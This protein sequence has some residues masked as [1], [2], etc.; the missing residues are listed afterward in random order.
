MSCKDVVAIAIMQ[1]CN[2]HMLHFMSLN[3]NVAIN[4]IFEINVA[5]VAIGISK[6]YVISLMHHCCCELKVDLCRVL[7]V[8]PITLTMP[9][10]L[11]TMQ[12]LFA[13]SQAQHVTE[14]S[15]PQNK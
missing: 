3:E 11:S 7:D 5:T 12:Q 8:F 15:E 4:I 10:E 9:S 14:C 1:I 6:D 2:K 13:G